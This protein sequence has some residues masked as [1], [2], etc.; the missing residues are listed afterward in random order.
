MQGDGKE[1]KEGERKRGLNGA[2]RTSLSRRDY[3]NMHVFV[4]ACIERGGC[5]DMIAYE[6]KND[7]AVK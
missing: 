4:R 6:G 5:V 1:E 3:L 7:D 2:K